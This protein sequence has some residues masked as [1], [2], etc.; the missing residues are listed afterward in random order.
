MYCTPFFGIFSPGIKE[1]KSAVNSNTESAWS[2][3]APSLLLERLILRLL[4]ASNA[5]YYE[6]LVVEAFPWSREKILLKLQMFD[7]EGFRLFHHSYYHLILLCCIWVQ[8]SVQ[9]LGL[10]PSSNSIVLEDDGCGWTKGKAENRKM[11][12]WHVPHTSSIKR[13][14]GAFL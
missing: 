8:H 2:A 5:S 14:T 9:N 10:I 4:L 13:T 6:K 7:S 12:F 3:L 1:E 11:R